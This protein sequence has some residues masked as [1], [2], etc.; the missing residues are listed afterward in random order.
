MLNLVVF[1]ENL[2]KNAER[3][4]NIWDSCDSYVS[5]NPSKDT[6]LCPVRCQVW[7]CHPF[8]KQI[9][10]QMQIRG[11]DLSWKPLC[12]VAF[13]GTNTNTHCSIRCDAKSDI[14]I[15]LSA[16]SLT[17]ANPQQSV[18]FRFRNFSVSKLFYFFGGFGFGIK[19]IWYRKKY[20][21]RFRKFL[22]SIKVS[23][24]VS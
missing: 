5:A 24:S 4:W 7:Y 13:F 20:R 9:Q 3:I 21:N 10:I 19:K 8:V 22:V 23:V 12:Y 16:T 11:T 1:G 18:T 17:W 2:K 14:A 15:L 6:L